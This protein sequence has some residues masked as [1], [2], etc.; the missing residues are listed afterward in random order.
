MAAVEWKIGSNV[1]EDVFDCSTATKVCYDESKEFGIGD[2]GLFISPPVDWWWGH[3]DLP[4]ITCGSS[5]R[6]LNVFS[7]G[8]APRSF[9]RRWFRRA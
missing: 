2:L 5:F 9:F 7:E 6:R 8:M 3:G 1:L 4:L